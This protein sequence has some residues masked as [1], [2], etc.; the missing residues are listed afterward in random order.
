LLQQPLK[1]DEEENERIRAENIERARKL[2]ETIQ[3]ERDA[4]QYATALFAKIVDECEAKYP[5]I[6]IRE[7]PY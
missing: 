2:R 1:A 7:V 5:S 6:R 4:E 3:S